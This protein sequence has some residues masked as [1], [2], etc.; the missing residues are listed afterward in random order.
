MEGCFKILKLTLSEEQ[1]QTVR[2]ALKGI[3][4]FYDFADKYGCCYN[5]SHWE[6][7]VYEINVCNKSF[8]PAMT[9]CTCVCPRHFDRDLKQRETNPYPAFELVPC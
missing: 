5:C 8:P 7:S 1:K 2:D 3:K 6:R 4:S 9:R